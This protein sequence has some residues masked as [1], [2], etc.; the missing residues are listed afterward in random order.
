MECKRTD[1][2]SNKLKETWETISKEFSTTGTFRDP[3]ILRRK[4]ENLK[5][6][7]K[8][9]FADFKCQIK[10]TGGG[11]STNIVFNSIDETIQSMLGTQLTGMIS[12]FDSDAPVVIQNI[13]EGVFLCISLLY[14]FM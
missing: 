1:T 11:E 9:K 8:K 10:G 3:V 14:I 5:K 6:K 7:A 13:D 2:N 4:Y 12:Q